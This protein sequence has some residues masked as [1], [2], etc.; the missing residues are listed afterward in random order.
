MFKTT[1]I[2]AGGALLI[3]ATAP[4]FAHADQSM[5]DQGSQDRGQWEQWF[6]S[7][8]AGDYKTGAFFWVSQRSLQADE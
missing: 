3:T 5:F 6:N 8:P 4:N 7:L 1:L 2:A